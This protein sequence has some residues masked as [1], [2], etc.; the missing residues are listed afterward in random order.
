MPGAYSP[1]H[2]KSTARCA[3]CRRPL[4]T[5][6][7]IVAANDDAGQHFTFPI[8]AHCTARLDRLPVRLQRR[9]LQIAIRHL[10]SAPAEYDVIFHGSAAAAAIF[11]RLEVERLSAMRHDSL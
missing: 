10:A 11:V 8:C 9:H 6:G 7:R 4:Q 2:L 3:Y 5:I 1:L